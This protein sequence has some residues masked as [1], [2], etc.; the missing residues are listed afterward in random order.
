MLLMAYNDMNVA[1]EEVIWFLDS[2]CSNHMC[3]KKEY[4]SYLDES[5]KD[6]IKLGNNSSMNVTGKGNIQLN[7]N[8]KT[9]IIIIVFFLFLI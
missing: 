5:Y 4:F 1:N 6:S 9:Y 2:G 7:M 3:E 8:D